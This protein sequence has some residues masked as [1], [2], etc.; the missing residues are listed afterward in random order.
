M[1]SPHKTTF[2]HQYATWLHRNYIWI[3]LF[4]LLAFFAGSFY[5]VK[6]YKNLR[7]DV[8]EL[9]P[10]SAPSVQDLK[11]AQ[12]RVSG[13]NHLEIVIETKDYEAGKR[14]Q[15]DLTK[16]LNE[17][18]KDIVSKVKSDILV[19]KQFFD[20]NK[21]LY[22]DLQDW[23]SALAYAKKKA[24][25]AAFDLGLDDQ[26]DEN[27]FN[28]SDLEKKYEGRTSQFSHFR[29][30]LFQSKDGFTR[31]ILAFLPGK[32]TDMHS[33]QKL[34]DAAKELIQK[35]NPTSYAP[36][37]V[38]GLGG[39]VQNLVEEHHGL[40]HDLISSFVIVTILVTLALYLFYQSMGAVFAL[41]AALFVGVVV[42]F[43]LCYFLVGYLNANTAFL[44]SIVIGNG[45]NFGAIFL[46]R[47]QEERKQKTSI[48]DALEIATAGTF[49]PTLTAA[50]A[51]SCA[52]GSLMLTNF[53][54]FNQ[55]GVIGALGMALCWVATYI[56]LP[57]F[58]VLWE[59]FGRITRDRSFL[60]FPIMEYVAKIVEQHYKKIA[61]LSVLLLIVSLIGIARLSK[62]T[63]ESDLT[64]LRNKES[65][66]HGSG[67]WGKKVDDIFG[68]TLSPTAV[69]TNSPEET[70]VVFQRIKEIHEREG[71]RSP[72]SQIT[73]VDD[74][75]PDQQSE[76]IKV[77]GE[78]QKLLTPSARAKLPTKEREWVE[79][80]LPNSTPKQISA[81]ELPPDL[82]IPFQE[83]N[84]RI[85]TIIHV[86]PRLNSGK[87]NDGKKTSS[88]TWDGEEV[89]RY[90]QLLREA[91]NDTKVNAVI[92]GQPPVSADMLIAISNDGPKATF[93][94]FLSVLILVVVM[95]PNPKHFSSIIISL[96]FG[97][98]M[99][100]GGMGYFGWKIN[101]LNFITLPIT[102]GIGV[103]YAVNVF[104]RYHEER[105]HKGNS[106]GNVIRS[107]GGAVVLCSLSTIIGY[108]SLLLSGSQAFV[109]FGHLAVLGEFVCIFSA[110][111]CM[112][113]VWLAFE[114][115][116]KEV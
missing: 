4:S 13:L 33:N 40:V 102:F 55:F 35:L 79:K 70:K 107:T 2:A 43:G 20:R 12:G 115:K 46:A 114:R 8:E 23:K 28:P 83:S 104:G 53:R 48:A 64:K 95:F 93:W 19:E 6:L 39:D 59:K 75:L 80:F 73:I 41:S 56:S 82:L 24:G 60:S 25:K 89:I 99:M 21:L 97:V 14:F 103:D 63:I 50:L 18:P 96:L 92:A 66:L 57:A 78:L 111:F 47:Y 108:G 26:E 44:G 49:R 72:F 52:Y 116:K 45:I 5:T 85:G 51:A 112:P 81:S 88:G 98:A 90:T 110:I 61:Y 69:L 11:K 34:S 71:N 91:I 101:F 36:D 105:H 86:Y 87:N 68:R 30:G 42:N 37:L 74:L 113:A 67:F 54:G 65:L 38:V 100:V 16:A 1:N 3:C 62:S 10:E 84:G 17:L 76:K 58:L 22:I 77:I 9:L 15:I 106:I 7:T 109:S 94:A 32:A 29:D 27:E 31:I